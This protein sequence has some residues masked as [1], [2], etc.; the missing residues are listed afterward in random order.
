M[1][2]QGIYRK[3]LLTAMWSFAFSSGSEST[4]DQDDLNM[5]EA[6]AY[7]EACKK[8]MC[9]KELS[10]KIM[11]TNISDRFVDCQHYNQNSSKSLQYVVKYLRLIMSDNREMSCLAWDQDTG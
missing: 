1:D 8:N 4:A 7:Y 5:N 3:E 2:T 10:G 9:P 6:H 11:N